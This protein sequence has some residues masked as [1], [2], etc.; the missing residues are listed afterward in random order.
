MAS[1]DLE[2]RL[3]EKVGNEKAAAY[4]E[5]EDF[6][7][8]G[9]GLETYEDGLQHPIELRRILTGDLSLEMSV[10]FQARAD[11]VFQTLD[12][13]SKKKKTGVEILDSHGRS[14][15]SSFSMPQHW[16]EPDREEE[17]APAPPSASEELGQ[18]LLQLMAAQGMQHSSIPTA[19]IATTNRK[20][21][22]PPTAQGAFDPETG[23]VR[24]I[25]R[26]HCGA[27][28]A[29][30]K[31]RR[32]HEKKHCPNFGK[33][34]QPRLRGRGRG[35]GHPTHTTMGERRTYE[36]RICG[37]VLRTYEGRRLHEKL[38]HVAKMNM[39]LAP[40]MEAEE[41][42][43]S[44]QILLDHLKAAGLDPSI[45]DESNVG[46]NQELEKDEVEFGQDESFDNEDEED[47]DED[48]PDEEEEEVGDARGG[49]DDD[50]VPAS[51]S[52]GIEESGGPEEDGDAQS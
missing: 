42:R 4:L 34:A 45:L 20:P 26:L 23:S 40:Q 38:Q 13:P 29:S 48:E 3:E 47:E 5:F 22:R 30:A 16:L 33:Y 17:P 51:S 6:S 9:L 50:D 32:K 49:V 21:G 35:A 31:G 19:G 11:D 41:G 18:S 37:K 27:S 24:Y 52:S 10:S 8:T 15:Y 2:Q 14:V 28:L 12:Y 44:K 1:S 25:C 46:E 43:D 7:H 39:E 36:C